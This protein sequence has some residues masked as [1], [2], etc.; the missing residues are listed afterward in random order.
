MNP[1]LARLLTRLYP[2]AWRE[3]YAE[4]FEA[5]LQTRTGNLRTSADVVWSAI[6]E[7]AFPTLRGTM[8]QPN[9]SFGAVIRRPSAFLPMAMSLTALAVVLVHVAI[10]GTAR[11]PDEGATAHIWQL[12]MGGQ[13]PVLAFF[14]VKWLP[15]A[16]RQTLG[17]LALQAGAAL[18][19]LA[20][21]FF[22]K[23]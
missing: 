2:R 19:S 20:P 23:L 4:E 9:R 7:R 21:V 1:S 5:L 12:L 10:F 15:R 18:A 13:M 8:D 3:R 14:A 16:P 6:S 11:E 22:L 17:V